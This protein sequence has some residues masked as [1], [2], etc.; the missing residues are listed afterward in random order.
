MRSRTRAV[1]RTIAGLMVALV[2]AAWPASAGRAAEAKI[3][4][5]KV[6]VDGTGM[7]RDRELSAALKRLLGTQERETLNANAI[8]DAAVILHSAMVDEGFQTPT[9][10]MEVRLTSGEQRRLTF[11]PTFAQALPRPLAAMEVVF[12]VNRGVRSHVERV[13]F[14]GLTGVDLKRARAFFR[15]D[16]MLVATAKTNAYAASR[17]RRAADGLLG[18]LKQRGYADADV[19]AEKVAETPQGGVTIRV[20]VSEGPRWVVDAARYVRDEGDTVKLPP[21]EPWAGRPW[22][23][24][25]Q[26]DIRE[27]VRQAY[28]AEGFP[29]IGV[30][31]E[32]E[33]AAAGDGVKHVNVVTTIVPGPHV[34]VGKVKFVGNEVT[35]ESVLR[36]RVRLEPGDALNPVALERARYRISRLGVFETVDL[37]YE[38]TDGDVRNPVFTVREGPRYETH[39]LFGYGA[40]EQLR[41]GIEHRQMNIFGLAHQSRLELVQS[42][43]S[44]TADYRYTVPELFGE[45]LD[46]TA[47]LFGLQ[48]EEVAFLRQEY[49]VDISVK[50]RIWQI[51][52]DLSAGY[53]YGAFRNRENA[54]STQATD[55]RQ[56]NVASVTLGLTADRRD[57]PLRP[58]HGFNWSTQLEAAAPMLGGEAT[59]QRFELGGSY[60]TAWGD[61]KWIHI[62][63]SQGL[64]TTYGSDTDRTLPVNKR[65]FPGGDNSIRGYQRGEA[66]PRAA[67]GSF[68]GAKAFALLNLELER[69]IT[70]SWSVVAFVDVLGTAA[71]LRDLPF[72]ERLYAAGL[73]LRYNTLIG[74]LRLEYGRN[75]NRRTNDPSGTWHLSIGYPF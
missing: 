31:V 29:D 42:M 55:E 9:V 18:E 51:G 3:N 71:T 17:V 24:T 50:R 33:P 36:R 46:G 11:D 60:H 72:D 59:Y 7:L 25:L 67:D 39:L 62:G 13:E 43:K 32:T 45:S 56:I 75:I 63:Y 40:Y 20:E 12:R 19:K 44:T 22:S 48:R 70:P 49:G 38:P 57:N 5:A 14:V 2:S 15:T 16:A 69:A 41:A 54:L 61:A 68:I 64:I 37:Q 28:Y 21:V 23:P 8:E 6:E 30:H 74:P 58:R 4:E 34:T 53:T 52:G 47:R 1:A 35:K 65:F 26:E 10:E 73:G 27:A 66:A